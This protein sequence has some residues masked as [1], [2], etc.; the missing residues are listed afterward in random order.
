MYMQLLTCPLIEVINLSMSGGC[1]G[2]IPNQTTDDA[3]YG[4]DFIVVPEHL[5]NSPPITTVGQHGYCA[6]SLKLC[7]DSRLE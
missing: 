3:I 7:T 6:P 1:N 2:I 5:F 4:N